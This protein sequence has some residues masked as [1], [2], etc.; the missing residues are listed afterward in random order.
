MSSTY[1]NRIFLV[2]Q[3]INSFEDFI[4]V[5]PSLGTRIIIIINAIKMGL[6]HLFLGVGY[7]NMSYLIA[8]Q[9][10]HSK[11]PLTDELQIFV[12]MNKTNP[13]STIFIKIFSE[14]GIIG[15]YLFYYFIGK[16]ILILH[17]LIP[18]LY[19]KA[20][21]L[22]SSFQIFLITYTLSTFYASLLN[23]SY[24][25]VIIGFILT[26]TNY[27]IKRIKHEKT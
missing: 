25:W 2:I 19:G 14:T 15:T 20:K 4:M 24:T 23:D 11:I 22:I 13:A 16:E 17:K 6:Q 12:L 27:Y 8:E 7:G 1:L 18:M 21:I 9:L 5:E 26:A 3:N 10:S